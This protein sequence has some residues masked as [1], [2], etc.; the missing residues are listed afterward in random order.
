VLGFIADAV[1]VVVFAAIGRRSHAES[2]AVTGVAVTAWPFLTGLVLGW[3]AVL[4]VRRSWPSSVRAGVPVW[5]VTVVAGMVLRHVTGKGTAASFVV[6]AAV[7]L[8]LFLLGWR[9]I[10]ARW[11]PRGATS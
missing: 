10:W 11:R 6:V 2:G 7:F 3:A 8:G 5:V 9:A 1:V 4:A